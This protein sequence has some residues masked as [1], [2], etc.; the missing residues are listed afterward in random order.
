MIEKF[1]LCTL[2]SDVVL[3]SSLA[4]E[5]AINTLDYIPGNVFLG[6]VAQKYDEFG[7]EAYDIFHSGKV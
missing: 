6:I 7:S 3:N 2:K 5:G 1:F 4:T